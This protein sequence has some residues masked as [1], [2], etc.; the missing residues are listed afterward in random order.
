MIYQTENDTVKSG[1]EFEFSWGDTG[2]TRI[3]RKLYELTPLYINFRTNISTSICIA[4]VIFIL[5]INVL[6]LIL[7]L[8]I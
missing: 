6:K 1:L 7:L 3:V 5:H 8:C 2:F 4:Y